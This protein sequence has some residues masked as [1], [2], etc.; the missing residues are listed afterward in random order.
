MYGQILELMDGIGG[1][2]ADWYRYAG[3]ENGDFAQTGWQGVGG[4]ELVDGAA[5]GTPAT[6]AISSPGLYTVRLSYR[7][8]GVGVDSLLLQLSS[9][10]APDNTAPNYGPPQSPVSTTFGVSVKSRTPNT[11]ATGVFPDSKIRVELEDG[12]STQINT[13]SVILSL[14]GTPVTPTITKAGTV[15]TVSYTPP[16]LFPSASSNSVTLRF[17]D[18]ASTPQSFTNTWSFTVEN[19]PTLPSSYA[20]PAGTVDLASSGFSAFVHQARAGANLPNDT[21][22]AEG[23]LRGTLIDPSTGTPYA[24]HVVGGTPPGNFIDGDVINWN[25]DAGLATDAGNLDR[26]SVV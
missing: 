18:N 15:T 11:A 13:N 9:M 19:Y 17:S 12:G 16:A 8:D 24:N 10:A 14:N 20:R 5:G 6:F 3:A 1:V 21:A 7:E 4:R 26:K 22:R 23:Q 25:Q 2:N